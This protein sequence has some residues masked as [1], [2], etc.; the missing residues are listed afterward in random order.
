MKGDF[1]NEGQ[2][3]QWRLLLDLIKHNNSIESIETVITQATPLNPQ[4]G[5]PCERGGWS[6][7]TL[8]A[9]L[10]KVDVLECLIKHGADTGLQDLS[11]RTAKGEAT[12]EGRL[13][14]LDLLEK[15]GAEKAQERL[16]KLLQLIE[17]KGLSKL[18]GYGNLVKKAV[19][20]TPLNLHPE[21]KW[22]CR[23][24]PLTCAAREGRDDVVA[25][26]LEKG[27]DIELRDIG[28]RV[29][30]NEAARSGHSSTVALLL[31]KGANPN[32]A[33]EKIQ[34]TPLIECSNAFR[35]D[36]MEHLI[37]YG[38]D[39]HQTNRYGVTPLS[40]AAF[41]GATGM[42][43][44]LL[45]QGAYVEGIFGAK[46]MNEALVY[47]HLNIVKMLLARGAEIPKNAMETMPFKRTLLNAAK[48][49]V[50]EFFQ[51]RV[52][53]FFRRS[54]SPL[55]LRD[56]SARALVLSAG[57]VQEDMK[58]FKN[59]QDIYAQTAGNIERLLRFLKE[60]LDI[61]EFET[62]CRGKHHQVNLFLGIEEKEE[63]KEKE[64]ETEGKKRRFTQR[65]HSSNQH[66]ILS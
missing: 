26:L 45:N 54:Y 11:G 59:D 42:V 27:A 63:P 65:V 62:L 20:H 43:E 16:I 60:N 57:A 17:E 40:A 28:G 13:A 15:N 4:P 35:Q 53:S 38:A 9:A 37:A 61:K 64:Q 30:L 52:T 1:D 49:V 25:L 23:W 46:P 41:Y 7:V 22:Q 44:L 2:Q 18:K 51:G 47:K 32:A 66:C 12:R 56:L 31:A 34:N 8:A 50:D 39:I 24:S 29:A 21:D 48:L 55:P 58:A 14:V 36:I 10:G 5:Q 3:R 6:P 19:Q 33:C